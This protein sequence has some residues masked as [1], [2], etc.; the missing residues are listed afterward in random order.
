[1]TVTHKN[2]K[3]KKISE[4]LKSINPYPIPANVIMEA[5]IKYGLDIEAE[6]GPETINSNEYKLA[7]A[8]IYTYLAGAP[9]IS[10]NGISFSF[11]E[12]QRTHFL[13]VAS[14]IRTELGI[15]DPSTGQEYGYMGEDF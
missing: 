6:A 8:D 4:L 10:H 1:M 13:N 15:Q 3:M 12:D 7:K 14:S 11:T 2:N 5:G 9:N